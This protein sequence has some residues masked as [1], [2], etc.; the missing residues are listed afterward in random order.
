MPQYTRQFENDDLEMGSCTLSNYL[1][2]KPWL[3]DQ[4]LSMPPK[5]DNRKKL[6]S[7]MGVV[8]PCFLTAFNLLFYIRLITIL[9]LGGLKTLLLIT[10]ITL[11]ISLL[12]VVSIC[13]LA[14]N[15][16]IPGNT[17]RFFS[18]G[19]GVY[20]MISRSL[21]KEFGTIIGLLW[22]ISLVSSVALHA[23][24]VANLFKQTFNLEFY[25]ELR[26]IAGGI[27][28]IL[29]LLTHLGIRTVH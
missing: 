3:I 1:T 29:I 13:A 4:T 22:Y 19:G 27:L 6:G 20:Y 7:L 10:G 21:G 16:A 11:F 2:A 24:S 23:L 28:L 9:R 25:E 15:G 12:T 8:I 26:L 14:T 18:T 17:A 5:L